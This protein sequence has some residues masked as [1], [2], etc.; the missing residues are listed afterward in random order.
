MQV[1]AYPEATAMPPCDVV[2]LATKTTT[3]HLLDQLLTPIKPAGVVLVMQNG[4]GIEAQVRP[5]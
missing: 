1:C 3:N 4:L 2:I 5:P